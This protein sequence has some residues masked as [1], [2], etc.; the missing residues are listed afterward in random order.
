MVTRTSF[1]FS[2][3]NLTF[4]ILTHTPKINGGDILVAQCMFSDLPSQHNEVIELTMI[5]MSEK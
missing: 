1:E 3:E 4:Y 2:K 5:Q